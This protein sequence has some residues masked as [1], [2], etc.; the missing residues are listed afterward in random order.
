MHQLHAAATA[1]RLLD[2]DEIVL[3]RPLFHRA[4]SALG[5]ADGGDGIALGLQHILDILL[6]LRTVFD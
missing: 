6:I 3:L 2:D 5:I 4:Q 1:H